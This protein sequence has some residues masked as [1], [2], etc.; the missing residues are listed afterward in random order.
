M[1]QKPASCR[2]EIG[3]GIEDLGQAKFDETDGEKLARLHRVNEN[4]R[5][6]TA[7]SEV[8]KD[9]NICWSTCQGRDDC[10]VFT[11]EN[12]QHYRARHIDEG[13]L[14]QVAA[15]Y[16]KA[17]QTA[18]EAEEAGRHLRVVVAREQERDVPLSSL[19]DLYEH[20]IPEA[21]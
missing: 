1:E 8:I 13:D 14:E 10:P 21:S 2:V 17:E 16:A 18:M 19:E 15:T 12:L 4:L 20:D 11:G 5:R 3:Q 6:A 7:F 9:P